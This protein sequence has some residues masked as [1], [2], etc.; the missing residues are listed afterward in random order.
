MSNNLKCCLT[1][2]EGNEE[3]VRKEAKQVLL[4]VCN[5]ILL[6]P[7]ESNYRMILLADDLV[8]NKLLP[9]A[10]AIECLVEAGFIK[11]LNHLL[12]EL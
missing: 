9:A 3:Y 2:L 6:Y 1:I 4:N 8:T 10:G 7:E 12:T 5:N 11:V